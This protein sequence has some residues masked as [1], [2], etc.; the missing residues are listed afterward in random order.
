MAGDGGDKVIEMKRGVRSEILDDDAPPGPEVTP[1]SREWTAK[2][3]AKPRAARPPEAKP[4]EGP[5]AAEPSGE[6]P[7]A[8][9]GAGDPYD[10][11]Y[12]RPSAR[13]LPGL[14]LVLA[15]GTRRSYPYNGR[16]GGPDWLETPKDG[17]GIVQRFSDVV[18]V[19]TVLAGRGLDE[20]FELLLYQKVAWVRAL[21]AGKMVSHRAMPVITAMLIRPWKPDQGGG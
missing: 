18:P 11:A 13:M 3:D 14:C 1:G 19:E 7:A 2:L 15:D 5:D 20:L 8:I 12:G 4:K 6:E 10:K 16:V 17:L 9:P 21:P